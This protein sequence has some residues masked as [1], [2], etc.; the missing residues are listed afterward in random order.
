[1]LE[2]QVA[3]LLIYSSVWEDEVGQAFFSVLSAMQQPEQNLSQ[4]LWAYGQ[5]FK[6]LSAT[7]KSWQDYLVQRILESDNPFSLQ[8]QHHSL[9]QLPAEL[10]EAVQY[11]LT[12]LQQLWQWHVDDLPQAIGQLGGPVLPALPSTTQ[13]HDF[14]T[15]SFLKEYDH[16]ADALPA[17]AEYHRQVGCGLMAQYRAFSW[18][19][20]QLQGHPYPDEIAMDALVGYEDQRDQLLNNTEALLRG[21]PALN[22]LLYGSRGAGKSAM[23]KALLPLYG[24]RG[25]RLIEVRKSALIELPQILE[26]L[27]NCPQK[28]IIFVDDLSFEEDEESYKALKVVLEGHVAARPHNVIVYATSNRR[29]LIREFFDD[30]PSPSDGDEIHAWDT[31]QEKLSLSDRFGLT[32]T[33]TPANQE[34]YLKMVFHLAGKANLVLDEAELKFRALQ[35]ATRHNGRSGRTA[36]QFIDFLQAELALAADSGDLG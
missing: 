4:V 3:S 32:L 7:Q 9:E 17:L 8:V 15:V 25:L 24:D 14:Q 20:G 2:Q 18:H 16:W 11:D 13:T 10:L 1:M 21:Y 23:I 28:F 12:V 5:L 19:E 27:Q 34:T 6:A 29:H 31:V 22:I 30:R 33:F 35:W 36:R 26:S